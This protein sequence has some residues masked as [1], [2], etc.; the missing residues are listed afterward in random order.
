MQ[1]KGKAIETF[2]KSLK[3]QG[4]GSGKQLTLFFSYLEWVFEQKKRLHGIRKLF[5]EKSRWRGICLN[6]VRRTDNVASEERQAQF[7][8]RVG[9]L[10]KG[11]PEIQSPV[12][13]SCGYEI[14]SVN[15]EVHKGSDLLRGGEDS[16][17]SRTSIQ[18]D[19]GL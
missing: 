5:S 12:T 3:K 16:G 2:T 7:L 6:P 9:Q 15:F 19:K 10:N 13:A 14:T 4:W 11:D 18:K 8:C 1:A 17:K